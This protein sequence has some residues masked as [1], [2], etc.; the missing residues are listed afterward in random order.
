MLTLGLVEAKGCWVPT[1]VSTHA[2]THY[3]INTLTFPFTATNG[4]ILFLSLSLSLSFF[5]SFVFLA[6]TGQFNRDFASIFAVCSFHSNV[7]FGVYLAL[8]TAYYFLL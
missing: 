3:F 5:F 6:R 1:S 7:S 8:H 2:G 4:T